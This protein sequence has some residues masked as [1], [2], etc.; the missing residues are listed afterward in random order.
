AVNNADSTTTGIGGGAIAVGIFFADA[1]AGG[2]SKARMNGTMTN[3]ANVTVFAKSNFDATATTFGAQ[4]S[5]VAGDGTR[6][7]ANVSRSPLAH[8]GGD[9]D[10]AS[11]LT[12]KSRTSNSAT[13][14]GQV[15]AIAIGGLSGVFADAAITNDADNEASIGSGSTISLGGALIVDAGQDS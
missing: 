3:G 10:N 14:E 9:I 7:P 15:V 13:A 6:P 8:V 4:V 2:A 1:T 5:A 11:S 12:V